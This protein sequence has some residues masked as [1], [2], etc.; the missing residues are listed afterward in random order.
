MKKKVKEFTAPRTK[1]AEGKK[2]RS[3]KSRRKFTIC[4]RQ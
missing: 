4:N 2:E 1:G 3:E